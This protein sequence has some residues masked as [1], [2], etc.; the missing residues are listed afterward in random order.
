V[1][2][3]HAVTGGG[4]L[5][6][7]IG[8]RTRQIVGALRD[9]GD[10]GLHSPSGLD[11]WS[12]LAIV[13]HLRYGAEALA[14]MTRHAIAGAPTAYYPGGREQQRPS[15]LVPRPGESGADV[16]ASL[17]TSSDDLVRLWSTMTDDDWTRE[18][19][20]AGDTYDRRS[21]SLADLALMRL[22]E[23]EVHGSDLALGLDDWSELFVSL[24]LPFRLE[25]LGTRRRDQAG[26]HATTTGSW[27]LIATDGPSHVVS[28]TQG[29][30]Q[31]R[32]CTPN[33]T[34]ATAAIEATSRDLLAFSW[35]AP[36]WVGS[37]SPATW[38][39]GHPLTHVLPGP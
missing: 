34:P 4:A 12:R 8:A 2:A 23:C 1:N 19:S 3:V 13:C 9:L 5:A 11:G 24:A 21:L 30:V 22:T 33:T 37:L 14:R 26:I 17:A 39:F 10:Q 29:R 7:A 32:R 38:P 28:V 25:L 31:S 36:R 18:G 16:V 15:T 35:A 6:D 27:L 20:K